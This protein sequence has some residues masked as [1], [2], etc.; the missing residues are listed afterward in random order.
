MSDGGRRAASPVR[1]KALDDDRSFVARFGQCAE[2]RRP[3]GG[4]GW[5]GDRAG[6]RRGVTDRTVALVALDRLL[7]QGVRRGRRI[8]EDGPGVGFPVKVALRHEALR[9]ER[10]QNEANERQAPI[11]QR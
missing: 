7:A 1:G 2:R 8:G 6:N 5:Y 11:A 3:K 4:R 9:H 10:A